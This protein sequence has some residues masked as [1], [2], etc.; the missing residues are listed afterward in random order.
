MSTSTFNRATQGGISKGYHSRVLFT[1]CAFDAPD[2]V[3]GTD[4]TDISYFDGIGALISAK[5][6]YC[7][8]NYRI[9]ALYWVPGKTLRVRGTVWAYGDGKTQIL[10]MRFGIINKDNSN[11]E[12][13]AIQ[14]NNNNHNFLGSGI[15]SFGLNAVEFETHIQCADTGDGFFSAQGYYQYNGGLP[16]ATPTGGEVLNSAVY[17]PVWNGTLDPFAT[18]FT[19]NETAILFNFYNSAL[20]DLYVSRLIIEEL[21]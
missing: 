1:Y 7:H 12:F 20:T 15:A 2:N 10:N 11:Y 18:G 3:A 14:N 13:L 17:V 19:S 5:P 16:T 21:A 8:G 6:E 9:P 4:W